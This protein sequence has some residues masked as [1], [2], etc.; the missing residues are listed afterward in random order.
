MVILTSLCA[1]YGAVMLCAPAN[2]DI[3]KSLENLNTNQLARDL[4]N[5]T[6]SLPDIQSQLQLIKTEVLSELGGSSDRQVFDDE[7]GKLLGY[8]KGTLPIIND[9]SNMAKMNQYISIVEIHRFWWSIG[10]FGLFVLISILSQ[11]GVCFRS[12][13]SENILLNSHEN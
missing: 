10:L 5:L 11:F 3:Q 9:T 2:E 4:Q 7:S 6:D 1:F 8:G 13:V 12:K